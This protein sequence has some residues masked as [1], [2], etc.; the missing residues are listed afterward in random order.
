[1]LQRGLLIVGTGREWDCGQ[2]LV[3]YGSS[4]TPQSFDDSADQQGGSIANEAL[5]AVPD[6]PG[7]LSAEN[8][9]LGS[10]KVRQQD[11]LTAAQKGLPSAAAL[12]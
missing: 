7:V 5:G 9:L 1:M 6:E 11:L 2:V 3:R 8:P 4:S 12:P 10:R